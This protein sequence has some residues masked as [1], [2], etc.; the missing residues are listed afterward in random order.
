MSL[1]CLVVLLQVNPLIQEMVDEVSSDTILASVQRL[2]DFVTRYAG[3][4]SCFAAAEWIE[5]RFISYGMDSVYE[6]T[7][8]FNFPV[9]GNIVGIKKGM[10][11]PDSC[12]TVICAHFDATAGPA[13]HDS[14]PGAD[15]NASGVAAVLEAMRILKDYQFGYS[16]RFIA[17]S[18]EEQGSIG[19]MF[20]VWRA[21]QR[22]DDI[23]AALNFDMIGYAD[24][25]PE[26]IEVGGDTFCEPLIDHFIACADTYTT[27]L[28]RKRLGL[29]VSDEWWFCEYGYMAVGVMEDYPVTNPY[30]HSQADTIGAGFS[31]LGLCTEVVK[32][33]IAALASASV[34]LGISERAD[35]SATTK[36]R[37]V[38]F[39]NPFKKEASIT[40]HIAGDSDVALKIFDVSGR[41]VRQWGHRVLRLSRCISWDGTDDSNQKLPSGVYFLKFKSGDYSATEKVLLIK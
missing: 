6:D 7:F 37:L 13:H 5:N 32:A 16:I 28:T 23:H 19:S 35:L 27:L 25:E 38:I 33:G 8:D 4:D 26:S 18:A 30:Y 36:P 14:A 20:Y 17:F 21:N 24:I 2:Q 31:N 40:Y 10:V 22:G 29:I 9:P 39:P 41:L 1:V 15:D 34:P 11:Y 12:Y 3:H